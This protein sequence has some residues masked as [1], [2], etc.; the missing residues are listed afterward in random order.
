[1]K[2][3]YPN[4]KVLLFSGQARTVD[5]LKMANA[6]CHNFSLLSKPVHPTGLL[7]QIG[8]MGFESQSDTPA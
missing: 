5:L 3:L 6:D 4:C 2:E 7:K 8:S 1:M